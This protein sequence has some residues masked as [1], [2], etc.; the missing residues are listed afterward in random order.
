MLNA[1]PDLVRR[2]TISLGPGPVSF[3]P[4]ATTSSSSSASSPTATLILQ[5]PDQ[6][7][8]CQSGSITWFYTGP[9]PA[10]LTLELTDINVNQ[11][12]NP[13][14]PII[15]MTLADSIDAT[16]ENWTWQTIDVPSGHYVVEGAVLD[17]NATSDP[18][19]VANGSD[20]SCL[21]TITTTPTPSQV[22]TS[23]K[24]H[25]AAIAGGTVGGVVLLAV[26]L[27]ALLLWRKSRQV[28]SRRGAAVGRWGGLGSNASGEPF[29]RDKVVNGNHHGP[30]ESMGGMLNDVGPAANNTIASSRDDFDSVDEEEKLSSPLSPAQRPDS[31]VVLPYS[32]AHRRGSSVAFERHSDIPLPAIDTRADSRRRRSL[33]QIDYRHSPASSSPPSTTKNS[34]RKPSAEMIPMDRSSSGGNRRSSRKPVPQYDAAEI[35]GNVLPSSE[36]LAMDFSSTPNGNPKHKLSSG[37][38]RP[39]HYLMPDMPTPNK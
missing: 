17:V 6:M 19:F 22:A 36:Q 20:T 27:G 33:D 38:I 23:K 34:S 32:A 7:T 28:R 21:Q 10:Q 37:D 9:L 11:S 31:I 5:K 24:T 39:I 1:Q 4:S 35:Q 15:L 25:V 29:T 30:S 12:T 16:A 3:N 14:P 18:F 8:T 13:S 2:Q 26:I